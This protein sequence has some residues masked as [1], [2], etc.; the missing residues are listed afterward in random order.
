MNT[1]SILFFRKSGRSGVRND[2]TVT[3]FLNP[4]KGTCS[5]KSDP[6]NDAR[7]FASCNECFSAAQAVSRRAASNWEIAQ[8]KKLT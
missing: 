6:R 1:S 2:D 3:K 8:N 5:T 4:F 7:N